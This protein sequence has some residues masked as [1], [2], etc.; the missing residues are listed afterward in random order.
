MERADNPFGWIA[1]SFR[2]GCAPYL[3]LPLDATG[4]DATMFFHALLTL[5]I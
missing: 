5:L 1:D 3:A 2:G 4:S